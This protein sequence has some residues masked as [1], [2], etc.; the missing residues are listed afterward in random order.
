M[1]PQKTEPQLETEPAG[2]E[3]IFA[4]GR[5]L[6][7]IEK[8][9]K[10]A[11]KLRCC[12]ILQLILIPLLLII[13]GVQGM[14]FLHLR[15]LPAPKEVVVKQ[16]EVVEEKNDETSGLEEGWAYSSIGTPSVEYRREDNTIEIKWEDYNG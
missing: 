6:L 16:E 7:N 9:K 1:E 10:S 2:K 14:F 15:N 3:E 4:D 11:S 12:W 13:I 8:E 5:V